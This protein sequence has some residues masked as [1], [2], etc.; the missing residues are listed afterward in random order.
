[1]TGHY[2]YTAVSG[3][4]KTVRA[5]ATTAELADEHRK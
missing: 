5:F 3:A 1:L 2:R 4:T